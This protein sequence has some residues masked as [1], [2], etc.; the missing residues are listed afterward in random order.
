MPSRFGMADQML[1]I[2]KY[3]CI[4]SQHNEKNIITQ[5]SIFTIYATA[6]K[7]VQRTVD[8]R[9]MC[10]FVVHLPYMYFTSTLTSVVLVTVRST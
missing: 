10:T 6:A 1:A 5:M 7:P 3:E 8:F 4:G 9:N 2:T